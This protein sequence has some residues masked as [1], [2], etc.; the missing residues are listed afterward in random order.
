MAWLHELT[1]SSVSHF[2]NKLDQS[3]NTVSNFLTEAQIMATTR[4]S[5]WFFGITSNQALLKC[6]PKIRSGI[7]FELKQYKYLLSNERHKNNIQIQK[8]SGRDSW[9]HVL[10]HVYKV[11][12]SPMARN[13]SRP[14]Q[15][16]FPTK[17]RSLFF[18]SMSLSRVLI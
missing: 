4:L 1:H 13:Q 18:F 11:R 17:C 16:V 2:H 6:L 3:Y 9:Y 7:L 10:C 12:I 8:S 14:V 15:C 5:I